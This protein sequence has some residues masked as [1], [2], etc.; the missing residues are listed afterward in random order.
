VLGLPDPQ[1][2]QVVVALVVAD[3]DGDVDEGQLRAAAQAKLSSFKRPKRIFRLSR[4]ELPV[5][6]SGKVDL[7]ALVELLQ[8]RQDLT[9]R[10]SRP[11]DRA[12][13]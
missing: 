9:E 11:A 3:R 1:R 12:L 4:A 5:L 10:P 7:P 2:G 8:E 6:S 13:P